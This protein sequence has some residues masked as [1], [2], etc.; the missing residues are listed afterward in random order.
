MIIRIAAKVDIQCSG[1]SRLLSPKLSTGQTTSLEGKSKMKKSL[2]KAKAKNV[3]QWLNVR[4]TPILISLSP[5][6]LPQTCIT[7][8]TL[9]I[10]GND[11]QAALSTAQD[12][13]SLP[14]LQQASHSSDTEKLNQE[15]L[16]RVYFQKGTIP[17]QLHSISSK[18][19]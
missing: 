10:L 19:Y 1:T 14:E 15:L 2:S 6:D 7:M 16:S 18:W 4:C 13:F 3:S 5:L 11:K 12:C 8:T 9:R 17:F